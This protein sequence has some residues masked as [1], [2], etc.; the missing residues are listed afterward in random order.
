MSEL[1]LPK[2]AFLSLEEY[3]YE[4]INKNTN[5]R[6]ENL[7]IMNKLYRRQTFINT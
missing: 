2:S 3:D 4:K 6:K 7:F 5:M 1:A